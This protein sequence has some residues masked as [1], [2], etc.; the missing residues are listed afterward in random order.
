MNATVNRPAPSINEQ[1]AVQFLQT[2]FGQEAQPLSQE[3]NLKR[4][5]QAIFELKEKGE[6]FPVNLDDVWPL[7]YSRKDKAVRALEDSKLFLKG[8]D[9]QSLPQ[10]GEQDSKGKWGG[11]NKEIYKISIP[12]LEFFIARKV[13]MV[14]EVYRQV[15]HQKIEEM[16]PRKT[17]KGITRLP[18]SENEKKVISWVKDNLIYGDYE[19]IAKASGYSIPSVSLVLNRKHVNERILKEA[20]RVAVDNKI[21]NKKA[22]DSI[23]DN[24]FIHEAFTTIEKL[25]V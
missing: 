23:Y 7:V 14:F 24:E 9:Y 8:I 11:N 16:R 15:F 17:S 6:P 21:Q 12:C 18:Y 5:F 3:E 25:G 10:N 1:E 4:Y 2:V 13:R 19:K 22:S 20:Y